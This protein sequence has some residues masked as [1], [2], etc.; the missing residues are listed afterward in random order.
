MRTAVPSFSTS[1]RSRQKLYWLNLHGSGIS[2]IERLVIEEALLRHDPAQ[3]S[4]G[5]VGAHD[6]TH[7]NRRSLHKD[8]IAA[9]G[10]IR[11]LNC[12]IVMGIGGKVNKLLDV[13]RV[14]KDGVQV[15]RRFSGGGTVVL[16]HNSL[17]TTF[18]GRNKDLPHVPPYPRE[19]MRWTSEEIFGPAFR[20]MKQLV[21]KQVE[22]KKTLVQGGGT[23]F[24]S[25]SEGQM[26]Q[27][28]SNDRD[29]GGI[30]DFDLVEN[31]YVL[32]ERK[33]GG[34]AQSITKDGWLHHTSFLWDYDEMHMSY[35]ALPEKRPK[36]RKSRDHDDFLVKLSSHYGHIEGGKRALF[37]EM[38]KATEKV[39]DVEELSLSDA[40][41]IIDSELGGVQEFYDGRC[42]TKLVEF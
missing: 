29:M 38:K 9:P 10:A 22:K 24:H 13:D 20:E 32:G 37:E 42:R 39:F 28:S 14:K 16:D 12:V 19:L 41:S 7:Q 31:D 30:P 27:L 35:L 18:I 23:P 36:Y 15:V 11:N 26:T 1:A 5:I 4:W 3:R 25:S 2:A 21:M 17:W 33:I 34:N 40:L 8:N 6:P